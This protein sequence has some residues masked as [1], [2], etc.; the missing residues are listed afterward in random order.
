M[1][2]GEFSLQAIR[3]RCRDHRLSTI[4]PTLAIII[5]MFRFDIGI[6]IIS[7][8]YSDR[9]NI[10]IYQNYISLL[11]FLCIESALD[12]EDKEEQSNLFDPEGLLFFPMLYTCVGITAVFIVG[13][14]LWDLLHKCSL[15]KNKGL[16]SAQQI[17]LT[18]HKLPLL[19]EQSLLSS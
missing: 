3:S 11:F 18:I 1:R 19:Y 9:N 13:G 5:G 8:C 14:V 7:H 15:I 12:D 16:N 17:F 2:N 4:K 6:V 10:E